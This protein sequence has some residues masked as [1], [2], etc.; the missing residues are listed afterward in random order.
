[1]EFCSNCKRPMKREK[2][3]EIAEK[4]DL[5][6]NDQLL[7]RLHVMEKRLNDMMRTKI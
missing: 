2:I 1:M 7:D 5:L 4:H 3:K 6:Q